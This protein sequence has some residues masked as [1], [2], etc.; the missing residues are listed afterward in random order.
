MGNTVAGLLSGNA[1]TPKTNPETN[2]PGNSP[3]EQKDKKNNPDVNR[4]ANR[5]NYGNSERLTAVLDLVGMPHIKSKKCLTIENVGEWSGDWYVK[6]VVHKWNAN[7][8]YTTSCSLLR[9]VQE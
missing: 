1:E 7:H 4:A 8:G 3:K 6:S 5:A 2:A 9:E